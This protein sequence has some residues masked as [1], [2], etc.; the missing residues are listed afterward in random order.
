MKPDLSRITF[1]E[2]EKGGYSKKYRIKDGSR[3]HVGGE[4]RQGSTE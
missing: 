1:I 2:E 4:N 3:T